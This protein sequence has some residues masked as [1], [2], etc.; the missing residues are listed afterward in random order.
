MNA[1]NLIYGVAEDGWSK[2]AGELIF[3]R[4]YYSL[5]KVE[6]LS[7]GYGIVSNVNPEKRCRRSIRRSPN[8]VAGV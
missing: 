7:I 3:W 6:K 8:K 1:D 2:K 5:S 4:V